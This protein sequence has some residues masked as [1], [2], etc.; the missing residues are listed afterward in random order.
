[1]QKPPNGVT[2]CRHLRMLRLLHA[3]KV[4]L[5]AE[6]KLTTVTEVAGAFGFGEPGRVFVEYGK[7]FGESPSQTLGGKI[8][9]CC[10]GA[11]SRADEACSPTP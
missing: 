2:P 8:P 11:D 1:M 7:A 10:I 5:A 6:R 3:R 9:A 4:L